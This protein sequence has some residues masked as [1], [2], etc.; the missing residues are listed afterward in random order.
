[1]GI[2]L[3]LDEVSGLTSSPTQDNFTDCEA[4]IADHADYHV[5]CTFE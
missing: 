2:F 1:M 5:I 3:V 4:H